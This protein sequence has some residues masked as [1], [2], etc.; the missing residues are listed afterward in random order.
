MPEEKLVHESDIELLGDRY[1]IKVFC[2]ANGRHFAKTRF[3]ADDII[4]NDGSSLEEALASHEML[5]SR[6]Q[7]PPGPPGTERKT[8]K[9]QKVSPV[10]GNSPLIL[11]AI[12]K[13][14]FPCRKSPCFPIFTGLK[15]I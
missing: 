8:Q 2:R 3:A 4:I 9:R 12:A 11:L 1:Q 10:A 13:D 7:K 5:P 15:V 6:R 14:L